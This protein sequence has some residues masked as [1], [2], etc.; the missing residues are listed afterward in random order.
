MMQNSKNQPILLLYTTSGC[1]L[2]E[3]AEKLLH[4]ALELV[5]FKP[6]EIADDETLLEHYGMRIPVLRRADT[7]EELNWPFDAAMIRRL[8]GL[9]S[10]TP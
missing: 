3:T 10:A 5:Q 9:P 6:I 2:C 8:A 1:H 4:E 7:G